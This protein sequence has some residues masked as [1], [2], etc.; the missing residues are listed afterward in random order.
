LYFWTNQTIPHTLHF[1]P[2]S[3]YKKYFINILKSVQ[4][5]KLF[6]K[7]EEVNFAFTKQSYIT[8]NIL[9]YFNPYWFKK[10]KS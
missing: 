2:T 3:S 4:G 5:L 8:R 1:A 6:V 10:K 9:T 7:N